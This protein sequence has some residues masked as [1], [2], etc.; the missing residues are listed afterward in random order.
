MIFSLK[1]ETATHFL[2]QAVTC[3]RCGRRF[4]AEIKKGDS[5]VGLISTGRYAPPEIVA[6]A[7]AVRE[8]REIKH[9]C[10]AGIKDRDGI[11]Y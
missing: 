10:N 6:L 3:R 9:H 2:P 4:Q 5:A 1:I 11:E 7:D 8:I